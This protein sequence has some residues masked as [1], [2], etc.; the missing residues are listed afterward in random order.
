MCKDHAATMPGILAMYL[1]DQNTP[2]AVVVSGAVWCSICDPQPEPI[3][4]PELF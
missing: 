2:K 4:M 1:G 3:A